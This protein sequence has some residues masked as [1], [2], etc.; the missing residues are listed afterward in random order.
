M[1]RS[2]GLLFLGVE[3]LTIGYPFLW[4]G[5]YSE[6]KLWADILCCIWIPSHFLESPSWVILFAAWTFVP[7]LVELYEGGVKNIPEWFLRIDAIVNAGFIAYSLIFFYGSFSIID[8]M[9]DYKIIPPRFCIWLARRQMHYRDERLRQMFRYD[10]RKTDVALI[11]YK[12]YETMETFP[13]CSASFRECER[14]EEIKLIVDAEEEKTILLIS[15]IR[16]AQIARQCL[17]CEN[18]KEACLFLIRHEEI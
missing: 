18:K 15:P 1:R 10:A 12:M 5:Q 8:K 6:I 17:S 3:I 13:D 4:G 7:G 16:I 9:V 2:L 11:L 14:D